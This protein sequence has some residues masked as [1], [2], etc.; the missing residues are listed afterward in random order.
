M[1]LETFPHEKI[2]HVLG[3]SSCSLEGEPMCLSAVTVHN[4]RPRVVLTM[5][6]EHEPVDEVVEDRP[7]L[8]F[9][10]MAQAGPFR[11]LAEQTPQRGVLFEV[12][13]ES[14]AEA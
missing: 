13:A 1:A 12:A 9:D 3:Y 2:L 6:V 8:I 4:V 10:M 7:L 14:L 11:W 5:R